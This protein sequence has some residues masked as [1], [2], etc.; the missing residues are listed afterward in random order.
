MVGTDLKPTD[1]ENKAV[2][3][4]QRVVFVTPEEAIDIAE[5][6]ASLKFRSVKVNKAGNA[7][8]VQTYDPM[9]G[10]FIG[11]I[12]PVVLYIPKTQE[13]GVTFLMYGKGDG[14]WDG[15]LAPKL[16]LKA[17][18]QELEDYLSFNEI[19][20]SIYTQAEYMQ[21]KDI[22]VEKAGE[23]I[24]HD[25]QAFAFWLTKRENRDPMEGVFESSDG[26][27]TLGIYAT[28]KD[29]KY[30]FKAII[31]ESRD[32]RWKVGEILIRFKKLQPGAICLSRLSDKRGDM[33]GIAW[34]VER[35]AI[36][37][38]RKPEGDVALYRE[39]EEDILGTA[40]GV[41]ERDN[42]P[43]IT[44]GDTVYRVLGNGSAWVLGKKYLATAEHVVDGNDDYF[45]FDGD[46]VREVRV[47][48]ADKDLDLAVLKLMEGSFSVSA[49]P[50]RKQ[51][52]LPNGT[53]VLALG[54]PHA[55]IL[56]KEIKITDGIVSAQ[57]GYG[58]EA[59]KYQITAPIHPGN[60]GGPVLDDCGNVMGIVSTGMN[61]AVMENTAFVVK[62]QFLKAF[63]QSHNVEFTEAESSRP[64]S[65]VEAFEKYSKS[66]MLILAAEKK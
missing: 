50:I 17:F 6:V 53:P 12:E 41:T 14:F 51:S 35:G 23:D 1:V 5:E 29:R 18:Y 10:A 39:S 46:E 19:E 40:T 26:A 9:Y 56:G 16:F 32:R 22:P 3:G 61:K 21:S 8:I 36:I 31:L 38:M 55:S 2:T 54:F 43:T 65:A 25:P 37:S 48:A 11:R 24:P 42:G 66:V 28:P 45:V 30:K 60:S 13:Y 58:G 64:L 52:K 63:M 57:T 33:E 59:E 27:F 49:L 7:V 47:V 34:R 62:Y 44:K 4:D 20:T 15:T